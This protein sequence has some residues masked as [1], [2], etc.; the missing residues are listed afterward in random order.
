MT[1]C[2]FY[3]KCREDMPPYFNPEV[4]E[5]NRR[6]KEWLR[7]ICNTCSEYEPEPEAI[8]RIEPRYIIL[9]PQAHMTRIKAVEEKMLT[10]ENA[11]TKKQ[12]HPTPPLK[13]DFV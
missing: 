5:Y 9:D 12:F 8:V 1:R 10:L 11:L 13:R 6:T 7:P 2:K 4:S 3:D